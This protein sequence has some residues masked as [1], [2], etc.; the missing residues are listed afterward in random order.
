MTSQEQK[1]HKLHQK[2]QKKQ[3]NIHVAFN[4]RIQNNQ[5]QPGRTSLC[6]CVSVYLYMHSMLH[7]QTA[8]AA[9]TSGVLQV[10]NNSQNIA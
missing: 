5:L 4:I 2:K 6:V 3:K 7:C 8:G 9:K 10:L 1:Q